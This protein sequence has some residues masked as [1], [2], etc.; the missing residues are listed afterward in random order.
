MSTK[1]RIIFGVSAVLILISLF[2][3]FYGFWG[4]KKTVNAIASFPYQI[5]IMGILI[6]PCVVTAGVC[7][8][9]DP[10]ATGACNTQGP[11]ACGTYSYV[12]GVPSGGMGNSILLNNFAIALAGVKTGGS[13]IGGYTSPI[14]SA[15]GITA[16]SKM[17]YNVYE[18]FDNALN[19]V[20]AVF[21]D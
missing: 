3:F 7:V 9:Q 20:I 5:G 21:K 15:N 1:R 17:S 10:I 14:S 2:S 16:A 11:G 4:Y 12:S 6:T 18:K 8:G 19:F 13:M